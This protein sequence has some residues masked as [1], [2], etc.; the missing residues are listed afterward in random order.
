V[1]AKQLLL[2]SVLFVAALGP[3]TANAASL[4]F[5]FEG[6]VSSTNKSG[7]FPVGQEVVG[8]YTFESTT[9]DANPGNTSQGVYMPVDFTGT[10]GVTSLSFT[11]GSYSAVATAPNFWNGGGDIIINQ[12]DTYE[13]FVGRTAGPY[14]S[15]AWGPE[16]AGEELVR[17]WLALSDPVAGALDT[18]DLP[19]ETSARRPLVSSSS[20]TRLVRCRRAAAGWSSR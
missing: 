6:F 20:W 19:L 13:V 7:A 5:D 9:P 4:T 1:R 14:G 8:S 15:P 17:M 10:T 18:I 3:A 11:S 2:V 12:D 16:V